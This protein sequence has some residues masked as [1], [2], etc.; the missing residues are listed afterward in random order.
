MALTLASTLELVLEVGKLLSE[1]PPTPEQRE[2]LLV[3]NQL[4]RRSAMEP[5]EYLLRVREVLGIGP[6]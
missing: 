1:H 3:L 5:A 6:A 4:F 2:T